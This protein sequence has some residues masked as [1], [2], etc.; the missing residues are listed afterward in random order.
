MIWGDT[1]SLSHLRIEIV[2]LSYHV[3][4]HAILYD[5]KGAF[6]VSKPTSKLNRAQVG[7]GLQVPI[8]PRATKGEHVMIRHVFVVLLKDGRRS[9]SFAWQ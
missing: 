6:L 3:Q 7:G 8:A 2:P 9:T 1:V 4:W 5:R